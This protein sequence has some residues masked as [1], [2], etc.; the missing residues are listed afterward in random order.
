MDWQSVSVANTTETTIVTA[1]P[2]ER[3]HLISLDITASTAVAF[4]AT[5]RDSTAGGA[6]PAWNIKDASNGFVKGDGSGI[7]FRQKAAQNNNWTL[8]LSASSVTVQVTVAFCKD[9]S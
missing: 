1:V 2:S 7:L 3:H 6:G 8:T 5:L 4:T 9:A